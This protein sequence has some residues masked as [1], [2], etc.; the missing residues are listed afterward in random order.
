MGTT[1]DTRRTVFSTPSDREVSMS[2]TFDAPRRLVFEAFTSVEHL[3][4][5]MLGPEGWTMP[6]CEIGLRPG[7][8][9]RFGWRKADG[10][11]MEMTGEFREVSPHE[12]LVRT[13][14]WGDGWPETVGTLVLTER[15]GRTTLTDTVLYPSKEARD[16]AL[17]TGMADGVDRS[18]DLLAEHLRTR[19]GS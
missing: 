7:G 14:S 16:A 5:W 10:A 17:A 3:P 15:D 2:R 18:Y 19:L 12:R 6:I 11:T 9:W 4:N 13:E 1:N 8:A